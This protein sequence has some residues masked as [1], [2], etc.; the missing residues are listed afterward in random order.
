MS[1]ASTEK[2]HFL[3]EFGSFSMLIRFVA[4]AELIAVIITIGRNTDFNDQAWQDFSM[5]SLF[6][7]SLAL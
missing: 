4:L 6:A 1:N 2:L 5:L 7:V 3:P